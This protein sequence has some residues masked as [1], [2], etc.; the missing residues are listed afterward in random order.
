MN[1]VLMMFQTVWESQ[2]DR[3]G[4]NETSRP[5]NVTRPDAEAALHF[6]AGAVRVGGRFFLSCRRWARSGLEG[7]GFGRLACG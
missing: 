2:N 1:T 3:Q 6:S 5:T 7:A 4:T